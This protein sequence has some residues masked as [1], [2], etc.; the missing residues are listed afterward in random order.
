MTIPDPA[1]RKYILSKFD[2]DN[3]G[4]LSQDEAEGINEIECCTDDIR[5]IAGV[6]CFTNLKG[7]YAVGQAQTL[8]TGLG[9]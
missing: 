3:D 7:S 8:A 2:R 6:E 4:R 9:C 5:S 1:F